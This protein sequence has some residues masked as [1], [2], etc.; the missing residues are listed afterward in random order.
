M[1]I[2]RRPSGGKRYFLKSWHKKFAWLPVRTDVD[3]YRWLEFVMREQQWAQGHGY[4]SGHERLYK[5]SQVLTKFVP[6]DKW[7]TREELVK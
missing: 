6:Y 3:E 2:Y 1:K 5:Y 4:N 7:L